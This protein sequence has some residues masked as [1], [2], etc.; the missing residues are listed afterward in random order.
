MH[1]VK[2]YKYYFQQ[3][4]KPIVIE[5]ISRKRADEILINLNIKMGNWMNIEDLFDLRIETLVIGVSKKVM[6]KKNYIWVGLN[7]A[8]DG[9]MLEDEYLK[10]VIRNKKQSYGK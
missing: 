10:I 1:K 5:A 6:N 7:S 4:E 3:L 2:R 8:K 9:W